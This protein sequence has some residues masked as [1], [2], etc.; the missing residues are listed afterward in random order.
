MLREP[1]SRC[2]INRGVEMLGDPWS[3][4]ILRDV[5]FCGY[6]SFRE[7][8]TKS[9]EGIT[10]PTLSRRLS[11]LGEMWMLTKQDVPRGMQGAYSLTEKSIALVPLLFELA[12]VGTMLDPTT[13]T[14]VPQYAGMYGHPEQIAA[15]QD[16]L[17]ATHLN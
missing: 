8:L 12:V 1:R 3:L 5:I 10:P 11:D 4:I 13:Q 17:R 15:F 6:R 7:L 14:T 2:P 9:Q 16:E